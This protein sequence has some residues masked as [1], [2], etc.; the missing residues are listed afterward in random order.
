MITRAAFAIYWNRPYLMEF[1]STVSLS[2]ANILKARA[3]ARGE[4]KSP[5][6]MQ[7]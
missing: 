3:Q 4:P 1:L 2:D 5:T 7:T 6:V